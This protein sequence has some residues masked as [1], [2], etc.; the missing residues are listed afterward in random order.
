MK[1]TQVGKQHTNNPHTHTFV[2]QRNLGFFFH[3]NAHKDTSTNQYNLFLLNE[4]EDEVAKSIIL[5]RSSQ[6]EK[7]LKKNTHDDLHVRLN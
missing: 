6:R 1:Q 7:E 2:W 4:N 5:N 3:T